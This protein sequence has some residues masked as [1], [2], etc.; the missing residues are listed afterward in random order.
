MSLCLWLSVLTGY[1]DL[2]PS[3]YGLTFSGNKNDGVTD[4]DYDGLL[5]RY[6]G[7]SALLLNT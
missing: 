3:L 1:D 7:I 6:H 5:S 4:A 2:Y